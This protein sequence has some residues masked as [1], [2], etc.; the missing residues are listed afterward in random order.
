MGV[1]KEIIQN[2][3]AGHLSRTYKSLVLLLF[4]TIVSVLLTMLVILIAYGPYM[5]IRFGY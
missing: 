2:S 3:P 5:T 1:I 4:A